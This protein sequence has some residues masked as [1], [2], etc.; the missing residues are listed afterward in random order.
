[1]EQIPKIVG[2][3]LQ[4]IAKPAVHPESDLLTA[5]AER[6]LGERERRQVLEH[7]AQCSD[8][9][10]VVS[11]SLPELKP[12]SSVSSGPAKAPWLGW[13][14]L[15]WGALVAGVVVV[16]TAVT[17]R[18][19]KPERG[20]QFTAAN[21]PA[22]A[23]VMEKSAV[24]AQVSASTGGKAVARR[25]DMS[26]ASSPRP[27]PLKRSDSARVNKKSPAA[28]VEMDRLTVGAKPTLAAKMAEAV[29]STPPLSNKTDAKEGR[30]DNLRGSAGQ[31]GAARVSSSRE[32]VEVTGP[33]PEEEAIPGQAKAGKDSPSKTQSAAV[34]G[35]DANRT[36]SPMGGSSSLPLQARNS[37][38]L[39][40][41]LVRLRPRWTLSATGALDRSLDGGK[42]WETVP[43]GS[44]T[45]FRALSAL[46]SE[47]WVGGSGG[48]LYHSSDD[49]QQWVQIKP[50]A[51]G[52]S[53][54]SDIDTIEFTD[55]RHGKLATASGE[56][57]V[58]TDAGES[59]QKK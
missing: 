11:L 14:V 20:T 56:T 29:P 12:A 36:T 55:A 43:L 35:M 25:R 42:T 13:P 54:T 7:L 15:R 34:T 22:P 18:Y 19:Q 49:G 17:L 5:F 8:C 53:L 28:L 33:A 40:K 16:G 27:G 37:V 3:R 21:P 45:V 52:K 41:N 10:E 31:A 4:A 44:T 30:P 9:R 26:D 23:A 46:D 6:S 47:I 39:Q 59:W 1:M 38:Q 24:Q 57:W 48:A 50:A 2:Q 58:T 32:M 51:D